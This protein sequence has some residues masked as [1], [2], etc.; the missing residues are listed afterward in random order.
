LASS[1][2]VFSSL[3]LSLLTLSLLAAFAAGLDSFNDFLA[4]AGLAVAAGEGY[5]FGLSLSLFYY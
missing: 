2:E 4:I 1:L 3:S 5:G